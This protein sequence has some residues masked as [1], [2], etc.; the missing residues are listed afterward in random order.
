MYGA[1]RVSRVPAKYCIHVG[2]FIRTAN[3]DY[4][5]TWPAIIY[6]FTYFGPRLREGGSL[7]VLK[8]SGPR[9]REP[10]CTDVLWSY[11]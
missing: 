2:K 11:M 8:Y 9:L 7:C 5:D 10:V 4:C 3:I 1:F 6:M